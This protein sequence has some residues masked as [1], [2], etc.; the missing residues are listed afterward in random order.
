MKNLSGKIFLC[1]AGI[2]LVGLSVFLDGKLSAAK[3][4]G[5]FKSFEIRFSQ[6]E[7]NKIS[8]KEV[9]M[10][11]G[12][13]W[14]NS[15]N[16]SDKIIVKTKEITAVLKPGIFDIR[17]DGSKV[18]LAAFRRSLEIEFL[19]KKL[20][21][22]EGRFMEISEKRLVS[23]ADTIK[24]LHYS[25]LYKE[26]PYFAIEEDDE[27][28]LEN[29]ALDEK[30]S[31]QYKENVIGEIRNSG[32]SIG[33]DDSSVLF[34][35]GEVLREAGILLTFDIEKKDQRHISNI[36]DYFD[37][38]VYA[39]VTGKDEL[40]ATR[41]Q[42]FK[43]KVQAQG[44]TVASS[45]FFEKQFLNRL[46]R[47]SF[48]QPNEVLF[49][50]K[51]V[52]R[53]VVKN[54]PVQS[55]SGAF[56]D[57]LDASNVGGDTESIGRVVVMLR[58]LGSLAG[59]LFPSVKTQESGEGIF[60]ESIK[61]NDFLDRNPK[62]FTEEFLKLA[63]LFET[64]YLDLTGGKE[65][66]ED[67]K[68]FLISEKLKRINVLKSLIESADV[69]FDDAKKSILLTVAQIEELKPSFSDA[70]VMA[71]FEDQLKALSPFLTFLRSSGDGPLKGSFQEKF[72]NYLD[73]ADEIKSINELLTGSTGGAQI[74]P[75]RREE[76]ASIVLS[77][78]G[79]VG[80]ENIKLTLPEIEGDSRVV[81]SS[82]GFNGKIFSGVYDTDK[83]I[84]SDI[85]FDSHKIEN[86]VRLENI[87]NLFLLK[88][89]K[90]VLA[91]GVTEESLVEV[92]APTL[93][94]KV[95]K[96]KIMEA[97]TKMDVKIEEKDID[98][99]NLK[100][101][102]IHVSTEGFS[103][104]SDDKVSNISN[105]KVKTVLGEIPV[106]DSFS[107]DELI[108]RVQ[109]VYEQAVFDKQKEEEMKKMI[110]GSLKE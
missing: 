53:E 80:I 82:A 15:L 32:P 108:F 91:G 92:P 97:L 47:L 43:I 70:A 64:K 51:S 37:S 48:V 2:I 105:L 63:W 98:F 41:L 36:F 102:V 26:F 5:E 69:K 20:V 85:V 1:F 6:T 29:K 78:L 90:F 3:D 42:D 34:K 83:K 7:G 27:W 94:E 95:A 24:R 106:N 35:T 93:F 4:V 17:Y 96:S 19:G 88:M 18:Y 76:L 52:L 109:K 100:N 45:D 38:A 11:K 57:V 16:S 28:V 10:Q 50:A 8:D 39:L 49:N 62:F 87:K 81:I 103:F 40:A 101:G 73:R 12:N 23:E 59:G 84:L 79:K 54:G 14:I 99:G 75:F 89:G 74:S 13:V 71:Y 67:K 22:P 44:N 65:I 9:E 107:I 30:F 110:E 60:F 68:Q 104:D 56:D 21:L 25:K 86:S 61:F 33:D 72:A 46:D 77:D 66:L 55:L 58:K 31:E